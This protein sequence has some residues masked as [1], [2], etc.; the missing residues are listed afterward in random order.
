MKDFLFERLVASGYADDLDLDLIEKAYLFAEE[1]HDGQYR[2]AT[3]EPYIMHPVHVAINMLDY[4]P[5][6]E[7]ICAAL[8]HDTVEDTD[9]ELLDIYKLFGPTIAFLVESVTKIL[10]DDP[11]TMLRMNKTKVITMGKQD[12]RVFKLKIADLKHNLLTL[13]EVNPRRQG[14]II[15][16]TKHLYVEY[17]R[18][19]GLYDDTQYFLDIVAEYDNEKKN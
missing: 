15:F 4:D 8:L 1:K 19:G 12:N 13:D 10:H 9:T 3:G 14:N 16:K 11:E 7:S 5:S 2:E 6:T 18:L 17:A